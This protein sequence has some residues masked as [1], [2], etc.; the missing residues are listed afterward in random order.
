M[1]EVPVWTSEE[2]H[3]AAQSA[4]QLFILKRLG[5]D[6]QLYGGFIEETANRLEALFRATRNLR[7]IAPDLLASDPAWLA[8]MRYLTGPPVSA[9]DLRT[10]VSDRLGRRSLS[11]D[12]AERV[13]N[14]I[15]GALDPYRF[16]WVAEDRPPTTE[17]RTAAV[18]WTAGLIAVERLRTHRRTVESH[19]QEEKVKKVIA[20]SG[21]NHV[22]RPGREL[23]ALDELARGTF[24][25]ELKLAG[26][27]ADV[28]VR[29]LDG[30][31]LAIECKVSN[32]A[33]NSI[34]RLNREAGGKAD[35]W[36]TAYGKQVVPCAVISGVFDVST[37]I[38]AQQDHGIF[39]VWQHDLS[40]LVGFI[41]SAE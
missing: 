8:E 13:A 31:L 33:V 7:E 41:Q 12:V 40:P 20:D 22:S 26:A 3:E 9:D 18:G 15:S 19:E 30:R 34:K 37:L 17:E 11:K 2:L 29:L 6:P 4:T 28:P 24:T 27:K 14:A 5:E 25:D 23:R 16:P 36:R 39:I 21:F 1:G 38:K 10:I 32:S 35:R